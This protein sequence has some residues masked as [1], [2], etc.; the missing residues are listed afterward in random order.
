MCEAANSLNS[1][2]TVGQASL[3]LLIEVICIT[4]WKVGTVE[5]MYQYRRAILLP[6]L[7]PSQAP[8]ILVIVKHRGSRALPKIFL[9]DT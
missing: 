3:L 7:L 2:L 9:C 8:S 1:G 5:T 6:P 4:K